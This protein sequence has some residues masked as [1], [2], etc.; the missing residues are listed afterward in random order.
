VRMKSTTLMGNLEIVGEITDLR[1]K[2]EWLIMNLRTSTPAGWN[3][4]AAMSH[5]D[6][7][8]LL[9]LLLKPKNIGYVLFGFGKPADK[10][11]TPKYQ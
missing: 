8:A 4:K 3:L 10:N 6:M 11:R 2:D 7:M 9:K 1:V 5:A